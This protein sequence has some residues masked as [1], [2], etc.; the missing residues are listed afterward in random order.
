MA[1]TLPEA[2]RPMFKL[3]VD[4]LAEL[5]KQVAVLDREIAQRATEDEVARRLITI[6][7]DR[8]YRGD[9]HHRAGSTD[10]DAPQGL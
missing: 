5:D 3:M 6:P 9:G 10:R 4:M 7:R 8:S 1:S 2:A